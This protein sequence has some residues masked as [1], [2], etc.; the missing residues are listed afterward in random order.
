MFK[1]SWEMPP[2][3]VLLLIIGTVVFAI[4]PGLHLTPL[5]DAVGTVIAVAV[6][7]AMVRRMKQ[8]QARRHAL[9]AAPAEPG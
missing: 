5:G 3:L 6:A 2:V 7:F 4:L 1:S 9:A 8:L